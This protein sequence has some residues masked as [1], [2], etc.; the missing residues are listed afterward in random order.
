[1]IKI[2]KTPNAKRAQRRHSMKFFNAKDYEF[3][4]AGTEFKCKSIPDVM[5]LSKMLERKEEYIFWVQPIGGDIMQQIAVLKING[6]YYKINQRLEKAIFRHVR[7]TK[8][9]CNVERLE[10]GISKL[11]IPNRLLLQKLKT[12]QRFLV[13]SVCDDACKNA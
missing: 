9:F 4:K 6:V 7:L 13:S 8:N 3:I 12:S 1:M 2:I 10:N 5:M 11:R